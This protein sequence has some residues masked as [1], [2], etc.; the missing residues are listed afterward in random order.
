MH[1]E[2]QGPIGCT[3][4]TIGALSGV[5]LAEVEE[6]A[7]SLAQQA[8]GKSFHEVGFTP[9]I[10][11]PVVLTTAARFK[12]DW[13]AVYPVGVAS[14][15]KKNRALFPRHGIGTVTWDI[16]QHNG[17]F[18]SRHVTPVEE[19]LIFDPNAPDEIRRRGETFKE[20]KERY[21]DRVQYICYAW[22]KKDTVLR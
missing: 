5:P 10:I 11:W 2:R 22:V 13:M 12:V 17:I 8:V 1:V 21:A 19:G 15:E 9:D 16:Y 14:P 7:D 18:L 4:S 3:L 6:Y 20:Y